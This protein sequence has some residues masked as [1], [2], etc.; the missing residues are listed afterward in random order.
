MK[1]LYLFIQIVL[2]IAVLLSG[3]VAFAQQEN[4]NIDSL[5]QVYLQEDSILLDQLEYELATDSLTLSDLLDSLTGTEISFSQLSFRVGYNSNVTNAGRNF[6]IVQHGFNAGVSYYHKTGLFADVSGY[7]NSDVTPHYSPTITS[8][9][10][11]GNIVKWWS[12]TLSY[13]HYF[14]QPLKD[15][16]FSYTYPLTN[17]LN[18]SSYFDIKFITLSADY[19]FLFGELNTHRVRGNLMF[20]ILFKDVWFTDRISL[21]PTLSVLAGTQKIYHLYP[22]YKASYQASLEEIRDAIGVQ[23][24][25]YLWRNNRKALSRM[26]T[27]LLD[28]NTV[29][30]EET[31]NV[32]G[33]MNY[34]I[35]VPAYIYIKHFTLLLYYN[36]NIPVALPGEDLKLDP[37]SFFGTTLIYNIPFFK[38]K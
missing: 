8:L 4:E 31:E 10:Y 9:G 38:I 20:N 18:A 33:V 28:K 29:F 21:V 12:Y 34:S 30:D 3:G 25:R 26:A 17:A 24:F 27:A 32:F 6:G 19:S 22:N 35:S 5:L 36:F 7:W 14:Y 23:K 37:N 1:H 2:M 15:D 16:E 13:D 11:M